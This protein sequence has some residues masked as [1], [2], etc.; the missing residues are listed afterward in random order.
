MF[1]ELPKLWNLCSIGDTPFQNIYSS[2]TP[3][4]PNI[5]PGIPRPDY[6]STPVPTR[7]TIDESIERTHLGQGPKLPFPYIEPESDSNN[8]VGWFCQPTTRLSKHEHFKNALTTM[9]TLMF[10][11]SNKYKSQDIILSTKTTDKDKSIIIDFGL[12]IHEVPEY[13]QLGFHNIY[14]VL[15]YIYYSLTLLEHSWDYLKMRDLKR[16]LSQTNYNIAVKLI[17]IIS[18]GDMIVNCENMSS[19]IR[20]TF[21]GM[22]K[23]ETSH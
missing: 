15:L 23:L 22:P 20:R 5:T 9:N 7:K 12:S 13:T 16:I 21:M 19:K 2:Q 11:I 3:T 14:V 4:S 10:Y 1:M 17:Y 6:V 18:A 8:E